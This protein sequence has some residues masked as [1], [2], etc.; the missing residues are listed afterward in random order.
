MI[1][2]PPGLGVWPAVGSDDVITLVDGGCLDDNNGN[3]AAGEKKQNDTFNF[4]SAKNENE[5][6]NDNRNTSSVFC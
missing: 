6:M 1:Y 5:E 2:Y 3:T 4:S